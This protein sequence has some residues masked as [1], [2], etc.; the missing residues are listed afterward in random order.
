[1]PAFKLGFPITDGHA[2]LLVLEGRG[3]FCTGQSAHVALP[4]GQFSRM[5]ARDLVLVGL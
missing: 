5:R 2:G 1:M 4:D 3:E